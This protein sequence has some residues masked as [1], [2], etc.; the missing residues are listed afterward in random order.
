MLNRN[1][2]AAA[3]RGLW[4]DLDF[5]RERLR[6]VNPHARRT[7]S[8]PTITA[9]A[10]TSAAIFKRD[11]EGNLLDARGQIIAP[12]DPEKFR[13]QGE[14]LFV[15]AGTNPGQAVHLMDIHAEKGMQCADCHFAQDSHGNG[16]I[17]G[18]VANAVE[19][20][21]KDCHGTARRTCR[22]CAPPAP[23]RRPHGTNLELL[24][25]PDGQRRFE[26]SVDADGRR[27]LMQR[28]I[29]D[30]SQLEVAGLDLVDATLPPASTG[31]ASARTCFNASARRA[32]SWC[33]EPAPRPG[34]YAFGTG[35]AGRRTARTRP[36]R[37]PA[38]PATSAGRPAAA[39]ATCRSRPTG[40]PAVHHYDGEETRNFATYNP[41]VARDDMFQLGRHQTTQGQPSSRRSAR[42]R[43]WC[44]RRPTSTASGSTS[45][46][47]RSRRP[48]S[49]A[50]PSRRTSRTRCARPR[51]RPARD[52]HCRRN[53][54]NNAIMAQLLLLGT[55]FV[56]FVGLHAWVGLDSGFEAVRVTEWDEPQAVIGSYLQR[57]RLSGLL[58][59]A[60]R[61]EPA[62]AD[63]LDPRADVRPQP[64][65][66]DPMR[67][68]SSTTSCQGTPDRGRLPAELRGE[69]MFVAEGSGGFR[70]YDVASI[71][72]K[73]FSER[74]ITAPVSPLG[75]DTHVS[76][77][78]RDLHGAADQPADRA[79]PQQ[80]MAD[81]PRRSPM[82]RPSR[83]SRRTR[84]S[85]FHPIYHYA[86]D[87][88]RRGGPDPGRTSIRWPT[89]S[90]ATTICAAPLTGAERLE[91]EWRAERRAPHHPG[92]PLSPMSTAD[93]GLVVRRPQRSA[94]AAARPPTV[95]LQRRARDGDAV[96]LPLGHRRGRPEAVRRDPARPAGG[97]ARRDRAARRCAPRL[98]VAD[99]RLCRREAARGSSSST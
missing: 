24:R 73:G 90:R 49:R 40:R 3:P 53:N 83:C 34:S 66:R 61:P 95:P 74:I 65:R 79:E 28:S 63:Q 98:S 7:P 60:C 86:V 22:R 52:C 45:S 93:A 13:R 8:S 58:P 94:R 19:I 37:W 82:A 9:T 27:V 16:L 21:C 88:R 71:A 25:N 39:A 18:E 41:Q 26:W 64:L 67:S 11:R 68:S 57:L 38:S 59:D 42:P 32:R 99:L 54:D 70:V 55:N 51:P 6:P 23:P 48:A 43:R 69:Y 2:E 77:A 85:A 78:Q 30:P 89:A 15:P 33:R 4:G 31:P 47:R 50:R 14:G 96:P 75:Q 76:I 36:R 84:S 10:G 81:T 44:C 80:A 35:V 97:G 91:R 1:P 56:N 92:R 5:V 62:R 17:Y 87:H 29:V 20:G 12:S 46:S 72:N